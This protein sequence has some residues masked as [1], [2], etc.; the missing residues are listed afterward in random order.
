MT[1]SRRKG[2]IAMDDCEDEEARLNSILRSMHLTETEAHREWL[3]FDWDAFE[4]LYESIYGKKGEEE[5]DG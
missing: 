5:A 3:K 4:R 1:N 2:K